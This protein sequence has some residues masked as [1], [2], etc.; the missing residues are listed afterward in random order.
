MVCIL[1]SSIWET[2]GGGGGRRC[3][4]GG[5]LAEEGELSSE[6]VDLVTTLMSDHI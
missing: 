2:N 6:A 3:Y 4:R 1:I 5:L